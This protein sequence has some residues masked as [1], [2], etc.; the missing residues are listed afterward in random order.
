MYW[1]DIRQLTEL[2][3][4]LNNQ[5][6]EIG[7]NQEKLGRQNLIQVLLRSSLTRGLLP[8]GSGLSQGHHHPE[9]WLVLP[10]II[11][12]HLLPGVTCRRFRVLSGVI[13]L[14]HCWGHSPVIFLPGVKGCL[15]KTS[16]KDAT[17]TQ[18]GG[19]DAGQPKNPV[20]THIRVPEHVT[21]AL[22]HLPQ[23]TTSS[24]FSLAQHVPLK[25]D[26]VQSPELILPAS[27]PCSNWSPKIVPIEP[28]FLIFT[29]KYCLLPLNLG[30]PVI[31]L[32]G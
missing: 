22:H 5:A 25:Q 9:T 6:Q 1:N 14:A 26:Y 3:G 10:R 2:T 24:F 12:S 30:W 17:P 19:S 21:E 32:H 15:I 7:R 20:C 27:A 8:L 23:S 18:E 16:T 11:N 28:L 29:P 31:H 4:S 13:N